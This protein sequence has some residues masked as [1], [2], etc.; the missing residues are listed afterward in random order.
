[1]KGIMTLLINENKEGNLP[2][3]YF[4]DSNILIEMSKFYYYGKC[5]EYISKNE[6]KEFVIECKKNNSCVMYMESLVEC[7]FDYGDNVLNQDVLNK[8]MMAIDNLIMYFS[9]KEVLNHK[10]TPKPWSKKRNNK[11]NI[12]HIVECNL[13]N[14]I[15]ESMKMYKIE[16]FYCEYL[17]ILKINELYCK[18][19]RSIDKV[20]EL[21]D[22][23]INDVGCFSSF[24]F[25]LG[26]MLYIGNKEDLIVSKGILKVDKKLDFKRILNSLLDIFL[27][28]NVLTFSENSMKIGQSVQAF[29]VT[30]DKE[31]YDFAKNNYYLFKIEI[32]DIIRDITVSNIF[33][34]DKYYEEY[35]ELYENYIK[36]KLINRMLIKKIEAPSI[37]KM[38]ELINTL[39]DV[40]YN[41][42]NN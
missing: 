40:L 14:Y 5:S 10:G 11:C 33:I 18:K 29:L 28:R 30:G 42:L 19:I 38:K 39:E 20:K 25:I 41:K 8:F 27:Y 7:A 23:M 15:V 34:G 9:P 1:M 32:N 21:V 36:P 13:P 17:Y 2:K 37:K 26:L 3:V 22:F 12:K 16:G 4:L 6:I 31:F 24:D 35:T